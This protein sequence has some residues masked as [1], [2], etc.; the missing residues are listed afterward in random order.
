M[1]TFALTLLMLLALGAG[2][3]GAAPSWQAQGSLTLA[4]AGGLSLDQAVAQVRRETGGRILSAETVGKGGRQVHRI[5]VLT[6]D[7]KVR[8]IT[9]PAD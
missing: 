3:V 2:P 9:I 1:K 5:K 7:N 8:I 6:D 4:R